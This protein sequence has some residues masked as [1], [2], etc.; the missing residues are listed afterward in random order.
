MNMT[1]DTSATA[2]RTSRNIARVVY[3]AAALLLTA[4]LATADAAT[5]ATYQFGPGWATFGLALP[6]GAASSSVAVGSLPTQTDVKTTWP[7]G[8]IRFAVV[9]ANIPSAGAYAIAN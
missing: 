8:S 1:N 7:D 4:A 5:L 6:Q 3:T 9:T 2:P